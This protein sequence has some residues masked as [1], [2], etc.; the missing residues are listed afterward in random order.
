M[1]MDIQSGFNGPVRSDSSEPRRTH[2]WIHI[3]KKFWYVII[4]LLLVVIGVVV[5]G[6]LQARDAATWKTAQDAYSKADYASSAKVLA[7]HG[8]PSDQAKLKVYAESMLATRQYDKALPAYQKMYDAKKD[9]DVKIKM[10]NIYNEQKKYDLAEKAYQDVISSNPTY[11]QAYINLSTLYKLQSRTDNAVAAA[12]NGVKANP[13][14]VSLYE[15][16]VSMTMDKKDSADYKGAIAKLKELN[17]ND[18]LLTI[19]NE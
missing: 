5:Y 9:P 4:V 16:L 2:R 6:V 19:L 15:L 17:P 7:N 1:G 11:V 18:Q 8:V 12:K 13:N 14:S 10:G 3:V